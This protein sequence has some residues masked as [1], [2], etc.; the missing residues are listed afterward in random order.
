MGRSHVESYL[1]LGAPIG[2]KNKKVKKGLVVV[3]KLT[4]RS[5]QVGRGGRALP[6]LSGPYGFKVLGGDTSD[7]EPDQDEELNVHLQENRD[8]K[9]LIWLRIVPQMSTQQ[10]RDICARLRKGN[11]VKV[12]W[13]E[14]EGS[15]VV[16]ARRGWVAQG[17]DRNGNGV[18]VSYAKQDNSDWEKK[19]EWYT[20]PLPPLDGTFIK[21]IELVHGA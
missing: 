9:D 5:A 11:Q 14:F 15:D 1:R 10:I 8:A 13:Q 18:L 3:A 12:A 6:I 7:S 4:V 17:G 21:A 20:E 19:G 2:D 16:H